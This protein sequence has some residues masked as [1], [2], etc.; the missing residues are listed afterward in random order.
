MARLVPEAVEAPAV[1]VAVLRTGALDQLI[2]LA[3]S[4][5]WRLVLVGDPRQLQAV[6]R[7]GMFAELC[8]TNPAHEL[9]TIHRFTNPWEHQASLDLRAGRIDALDA[10]LDHVRVAAG[11]FDQL[12]TEVA[13]RWVEHTGAGRTIAVVAET[14]EH[15]DALNQAVQAQR[16]RLGQLRGP[17]VPIAGGETAS[18]GDI[19]VTRRNDRTLTTDRGKP[20]RNRDRWTSTS[21]RQDGGVTVSH[22]QGHGLV[23]RPAGYVRAHLRLGYA[24]TAHG[25]QGDTVDIGLAIVT[26]ATTHRSLYVSATRGRNQNHLLV[27]AQDGDLQEAR[28]VLEQ[29]LGNDRADTPAVAQRRQLEAQAPHRTSRTARGDAE[30]VVTA[31]IGDPSRRH[32]QLACGSRPPAADSRLGMRPAR[33]PAPDVSPLRSWSVAT[34]IGNGIRTCPDTK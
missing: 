22:D 5:R 29:V 16:H 32:A 27:V 26:P 28:D 14:N 23:T 1:C 17:T 3:H 9:A 34:G 21:I 25:H 15:V 13:H 24:A 30:A 6:G 10:Y 12:A 8:R 31:A 18:E 20:V 2:R 11:T 19:V 7:G 33:F 4:Q